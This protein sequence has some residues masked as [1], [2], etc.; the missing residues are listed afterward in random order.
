M[1][2]LLSECG[3]LTALTNEGNDHVHNLLLLLP[4]QGP[5]PIKHSH[6]HNSPSI[7]RNVQNQLI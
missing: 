4:H 6:R 2:N 3:A 1:K 7:H 5:N